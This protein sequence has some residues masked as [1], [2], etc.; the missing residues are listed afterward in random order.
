[1]HVCVFVCTY[2]CVSWGGGG[3]E[4]TCM[5]VYV[6]ET[7]VCVCVRETDRWREREER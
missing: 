3:V 2:M 4:G 1:M 5:H 6:V 7:E